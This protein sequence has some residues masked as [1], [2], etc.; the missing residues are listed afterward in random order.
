M[1]KELKL[2]NMS[3][4]EIDFDYENENLGQRELTEEIHSLTQKVINHIQTHDINKED[5]ITKKAITYIEKNYMDSELDLQEICDELSIS[6][7]YYSALFKTHTGMTFVT[8]LNN[9]K[10][11]KAKYYLEFTKKSIGEISECIG[12]IE[13]HYFGIVFKKHMKLSP[14]KYRSMR[15][16]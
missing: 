6:V 5:Y 8:Y 2:I 14:K 11:E 4:I 16:K 12:Y 9:Y 3:G 10:I 1:S 15:C 13:P 7:S